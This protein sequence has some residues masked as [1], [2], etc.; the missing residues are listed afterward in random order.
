[1]DCRLPDVLD[2]LAGDTAVPVLMREAPPGLGRTRAGVRGPATNGENMP[3]HLDSEHFT[4]QWE[5]PSVD[6]VRAAE[7]LLQLERAWRVL[8]VREGWPAPVSS[9]RWRL[10]FILDPELGGSGY[11]TVH[12]TEEHPE[13]VPV[14][15]LNPVYDLDD[16][17]AFGLS[18]AI[19]EFGHMIQYGMRSRDVT[20]LDA[21]YWEA[22]SEWMAER[23]APELDTYAESTVW[24][25]QW[26]DAP[27]DTVHRWHPYGMVLLNAWADERV[28]GFDGVRDVWLS[29]PDVGWDEALADVAGQ[30]FGEM[31]TAM[32]AEVAAGTLRESHLYAVP[33][34]VAVHPVAPEWETLPLPGLYGS[35][36]IDVGEGAIEVE[37]PVEVAFVWGGD[38]HDA[39]PVT[40][41]YTVVVT[42]LEEDERFSYGSSPPVPEGGG[43]PFGCASGGG[44]AGLLGLLAG[45]GRRKAPRL[46]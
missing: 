32:A 43:G 41:A 44:A 38:V 20:G 46:R 37:G 36:F 31:V 25:A 5:D 19:H 39:P 3:F 10:W 12:A 21:W 2:A 27:Y 14:A 16:G 15:W 4:V 22:T 7:L 24:Y 9:D 29:E 23:V 18:V 6:P 45:W 11:T 8:V 40:G 30:P 13:G 42:A 26:P 28:F 1:M 34:R 35:H 17:P 33:D